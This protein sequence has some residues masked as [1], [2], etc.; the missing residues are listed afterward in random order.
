MRAT[1]PA[2]SRFAVA[3]LVGALVPVGSQSQEPPGI[4][5]CGLTWAEPLVLQEGLA[6][7]SVVPAD[8]SGGPWIVGH[9]GG[10]DPPGVGR[11]GPP[12]EKLEAWR[13]RVLERDVEVPAPVSNPWLGVDV[14]AAPAP[15]GGLLVVWS[16]PE[17]GFV[18]DHV[19]RMYQDPSPVVYLSSTW[20]GDRWSRPD[21]VYSASRIRPGWRT[22]P[23]RQ[24]GNVLHFSINESVNDTFAG[25]HGGRT[26]LLFEPG[27]GWTARQIPNPEKLGA[28]GALERFTLRANG[29]IQ[30]VFVRSGV[31]PG[32]GRDANSLFFAHSA[33]QG[34][35]W[36]NRVRIM[37]GGELQP[38]TDPDLFQAQDGTLH[39]VAT[40]SADGA[41]IPQ[42]EVWYARAGDGG[43]RWSDPVRIHRFEGAAQA[44][45]WARHPTF[46]EDPDGG[47]HV[48]T[49]VML[50]P[51]ARL[52]LITL[53]PDDANPPE[54]RPLLPW[55]P[56]AFEV[57]LAR[58]PDGT[59]TLAYANRSRYREDDGFIPLELT[60][61][62]WSCP[63]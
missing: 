27:S 24:E 8:N 9:A 5:G 53:S 22:T 61:G 63:G 3:C 21:T 25:R 59:L 38:A 32:M 50:H 41:V 51:G 14:L 15:S 16:E 43:Q 13:I 18:G 33:D 29:M 45:A 4:P 10:I 1:R 20:D 56:N 39:V 48:F 60:T 34:V 36:S 6:G 58:S 23:L 40:R 62:R 12:D 47:L 7:F 42:D 54:P 44:K 26:L 11:P 46:L 2:H 31:E 17:A 37:R 49:R 19:N 55:D 35:T 52:A 30:R 28:V 57:A